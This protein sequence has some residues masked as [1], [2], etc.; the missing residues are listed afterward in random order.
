MLQCQQ[1]IHFHKW[2]STK[3][4]LFQFQTWLDA[5]QVAL[6]SAYAT[7]I[8]G[9]ASTRTN[10]QWSANRTPEMSSYLDAGYVDDVQ[11]LEEETEAPVTNAPT[12]A[13]TEADAEPDS[14]NVA[15]LSGITLLV[16]LLLNLTA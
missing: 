8:S 11:D 1:Q 16:A 3:Y 10:L 9:I 15:A 5:N 4:A 12:E 7:G 13:T 2:C 6:G 14:A